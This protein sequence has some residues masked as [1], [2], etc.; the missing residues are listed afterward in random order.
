MDEISF[1]DADM[2]AGLHE[3]MEVGGRLKL[4]E[5]GGEVINPHPMFRIVGTDNVGC[6]GDMFGRYHGTKA[7]NSAFMDRWSIQIKVGYMNR[8][9]ETSVLVGKTLGLPRVLAEIM[10]ELAEE[11]RDQAVNEEILQPISFRQLLD[12]AALA[13]QH[14]S[15]GI[16]WRYAVLNKAS[17]EDAGALSTL[18]LH[19][20]PEVDLGE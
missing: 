3:P 4:S 17:E 18:F 1:I 7:L 9:D 15:I 20:F 8:A 6:Q 5:N 13:V 16:G 19:K 10:T 14:R 11:S 12:W 2:A